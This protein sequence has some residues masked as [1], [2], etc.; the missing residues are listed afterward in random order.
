MSCRRNW[1]EDDRGCHARRRGK[2]R[3]V[4]IVIRLGEAGTD[5]RKDCEAAACRQKVCLH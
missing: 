3:K 2:L 5:F 1:T 4:G